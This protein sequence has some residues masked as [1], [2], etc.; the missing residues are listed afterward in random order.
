MQYLLVALLMGDAAGVG[1][2]RIGNIYYR[3]CV[4]LTSLDLLENHRRS[5]VPTQLG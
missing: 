3:F 5:L 2:T 1:N 4:D